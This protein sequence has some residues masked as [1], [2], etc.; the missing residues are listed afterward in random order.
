MTPDRPVLNELHSLEKLFV[1]G[2]VGEP[3]LDQGREG[4]EGDVGASVATS[5]VKVS[6]WNEFVIQ[7]C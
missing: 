3:G 1:P 5:V 6:F 7:G 2:L 4:L